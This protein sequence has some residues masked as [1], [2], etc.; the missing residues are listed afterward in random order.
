MNHNYTNARDNAWRYLIRHKVKK[1]PVDVF[2]LCR[3]DKIKMLPYST[4]KAKR[5]AALLDDLDLMERTDGFVVQVDE[6]TIFLWDD[7]KSLQRQR[8]TVAHELGHVVNGDLGPQP[9]LQNR[10]PS[11]MDNPKET[12][13]NIFASRILAPASVLWALDVHDAETIAE[14][15]GISRTAAEWRCKRME[16]LYEREKQFLAKYGKS[17]FL[18][19]PLEQKV[20]RQFRTYIARQKRD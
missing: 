13:A 12:A 15:C 19:S 14:L 1:L 10:E 17:C 20:H 5:V 4:E 9:T 6:I 3:R 18:M 8:F 7:S 11:E 2:E 16:L